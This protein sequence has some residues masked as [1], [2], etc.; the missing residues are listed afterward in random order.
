[1]EHNP[2]VELNDDT[3][4][5]FSDIKDDGNG[6]YITI[7]FET[8]VEDGFNSMQVN[9]PQGVPEKI[10]GYTGNEVSDLMEH[11][12]KIAKIAFEFAKEGD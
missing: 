8:P 10:V 5:T 7:Y 9:Y 4:I 12:Q 11:Y 6:E 1:M 2:L 3:T